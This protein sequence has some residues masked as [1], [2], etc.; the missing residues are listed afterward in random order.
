MH[1]VGE[2]AY[3]LKLP[4]YLKIHPTFH[5]SFFKKFNHEE[6]DA[7]R[8]QLKRVP[9]VVRDQFEKQVAKILDHR[10]KGQGKKNQPTEYLVQ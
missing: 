8:Q 6:F 10:I 2:V 1:K 7:A 9:R 5:V 4:D 3:L